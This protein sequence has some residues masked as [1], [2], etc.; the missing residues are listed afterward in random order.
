MQR[1]V[2]NIQVCD[3]IEENFRVSFIADAD[4]DCDGANDNPDHD[5]YWQGETS[6][7][8]NGESIDSYAVPGIVVPPAVLKGVKGIVLGCKARV[9]YRKT[10]LVADAVVY[11]IGPTKKIGELSV[12][13]AKRVGMP[14]NPNTGGEDSMDEVCYEL[15]PGVPAIVDGVRYELQ[16]WRAA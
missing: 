9:T 11:D 14:H 10:G 7:K 2:A 12:E 5:P 16:P 4:I 15:W 6:L 13:C 8:H 3:I 1:R